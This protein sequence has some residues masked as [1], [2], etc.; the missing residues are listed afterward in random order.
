MTLWENLREFKKKLKLFRCTQ[1]L[2]IGSS[3]FWKFLSK[4][5]SSSSKT[6]FFKINPKFPVNIFDSV[7][8]SFKLP[9]TTFNSSRFQNTLIDDSRASKNDQRKI[10]K[11][12]SLKSLST[13]IRLNRMPAFCYYAQ[14]FYGKKNFCL[15]KDDCQ[16]DKRL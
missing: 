16:C 4:F 3:N 8:A 2:T 6:L 13:V 12:S 15:C 10:M 14:F 5:F 11:I 9:L 1:V 7:I